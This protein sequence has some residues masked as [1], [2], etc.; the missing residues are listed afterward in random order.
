M[1]TLLP[2]GRQCIDDEDIA[3]VVAVLR[4]D[5]LTTG[6]AVERFE[7]D[8]CA[9]TGAG[10][11]VAMSNGTAALHACMYA[12]GIAPGDEVIVPPITFAATANCVLY[13]GGKPVFAD[14]QADTLLIDPAAVEA[15]ITPRTRAIIGVDYAGQPCD[16][17]VLR[18]IAD[19]HALA[20]VADACHAIG[21]EYKGRKVGTLADITVFSFHPVKH[22]TTGEGG[23]A[24]TNDHALAA[25]M[26][27]FRG[28]GI[29]TTAAEREKMGGWYYEMTELGYN[30]RITDFQCA[31][32]S[33]QLK[34]LNGWIEKRNSLA[35]I[36]CTAL[37]ERAS[38]PLTRRADVRHAYH[39][40]VVRT[41]ERDTVF[42]RMRDAGIG[43]NVHY[44]PVHLH[45]Y[46]QGLGYKKGTCPVAEAAYAEILTLPLWP[47]MDEEKASY[48]SVITTLEY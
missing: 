3:A 9:Y 36:Y 39:L 47:G 17:D 28:H 1:N 42:K 18:S 8:V 37:E 45:P 2:Y 6:P 19:R 44:V 35:Q 40:Y 34:K 10:Y 13:C 21:A 16:W 29:T 31:L 26:R 7:G 14:V 4:S 43:V 33:S 15:A 20:L 27:T 22:I 12:L 11:A 24:V 30:Y 5:F 32:G 23:M 41:P 25:K 38:T 48:I 46:Y